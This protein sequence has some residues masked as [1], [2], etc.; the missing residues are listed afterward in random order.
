MSE[1]SVFI[2]TTKKPRRPNAMASFLQ[3]IYILCTF[4]RCN[5]R[6]TVDSAQAI[7]V[8]GISQRDC[9]H[10]DEQGDHVARHRR[11]FE[12]EMSE[13]NEARL[14]KDASHTT[15]TEKREKAWRRINAR[16]EHVRDGRRDALGLPSSSSTTYFHAVG[17]Y[18]YGQVNASEPHCQRGPL[19]IVG[20]VTDRF[21]AYRRVVAVWI[22]TGPTFT[23]VFSMFRRSYGQLAPLV[24]A[25][26]KRLRIL[27]CDQNGYSNQKILL[28]LRATGS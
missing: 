16:D 2:L 20:R 6:V 25:E 24:D 5:V 3:D 13:R 14:T 9:R 17:K 22:Q 12:R 21:G 28:R 1:I 10:P 8:T 11:E 19:V 27:T 23:H 26:S 18:A 15:R 4:K 7:R